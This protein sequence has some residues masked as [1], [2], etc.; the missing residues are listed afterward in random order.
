MKRRTA[1]LGAASLLAQS[2]LAHPGIAQSPA[3][4]VR[5]SHGYGIHYLPL[6]II[7]D[8]MLLEKH[9]ARLGIRPLDVQWRTLDGG[10][11]IN[12]AML[13]G[14][15]D[16]AGTGA[17]GFI[18]LWAKA[19]GGSSAVVGVSALGNGALWLN[20]RR[21]ELKTL[22]DIGMQD[23]IA[24]PGIKTS[25]AAVVLQIACA[26]A[27]G[28]DHY[29]KLDVL[30]VGLPHPE[31]MA[32]LT[33]GRTEITCHFASPPFSNQ[34]LTFPGIHRIISTADML[35]P[36]TVDVVYAPRRF[37]DTHPGIMQAFIAAKDEADAMI[38]NDKAA[39]TES[40]QR[41]SGL[42]MQA[43][44]IRQMLDDPETSFTT[45]PSGV[46]KY[47]DF[48]FRANLI[49]VQPASWKDMFMPQIHDRSGS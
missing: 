29:S 40:F 18:T 35:G 49:K 43:T 14:A 6:M 26:Q 13:S 10:S 39:A 30:T 15:L 46:T 28:I 38:A 19:R 45:A 33:S 3:R 24:V 8:R 44:M 7:R 2:G 4:P 12:D 22:A 9:A 41:V 21:P 23:R 36:I 17:P 32:A 25:F 5:L 27:F 20:T 47:S 11:T 42:K 31:A 16:I 48:L 1:L 37:V 34:E